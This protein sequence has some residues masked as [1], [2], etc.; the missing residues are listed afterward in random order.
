[1][2]ERE[3]ERLRERLNRWCEKETENPYIWHGVRARPKRYRERIEI[4]RVHTDR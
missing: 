3:G 1:M 2:R 4:Q